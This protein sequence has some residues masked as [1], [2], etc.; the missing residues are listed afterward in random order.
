MSSTILCSSNIL[1]LVTLV[2]DPK[3]YNKLFLSN[4]AT[5]NIID[6]LKRIPGVA[7]VK[8]FG[9]QDY[10]MRIWLQPDKMAQLGVTTSEIAA[11]INEQNAQN[12]AGKI[13]QVPTTSEQKLTYTVT[14]KGRLLTEEEFGDILFAL[15]NLARR[16]QIDAEQAL[17]R[18]NTKFMKRFRKM[19]EIAEKPLTDLTFQEWDNL[20]NKVK[21]LTAT[22]NL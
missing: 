8:N 14:A 12:A 10:S 15:V 7:D 21:E 2:A 16:N 11:A 3:R 13:G 9:A 19:E 6:D 18:S 4:Y 5:L 1:Q 17:I 22:E 20:W